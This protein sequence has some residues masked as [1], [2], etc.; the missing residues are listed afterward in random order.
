[1]WSQQSPQR[2]SAGAQCFCFLATKAHF[3]SS[4][5]S[6][7]EGGKGHVLV[8]AVVGVLA[9]PQGVADDRVLIDPRQ[10]GGLAHAAAV[11]EVLEDGQGLGVG[12]ANAE[13]GG[14]LALGEALL[15]GAAGEHPAAVAAVVEADAEV[16]LAAQTVVLT[17]GVLTAEQV[18]LIHA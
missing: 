13:E 3:S 11:L 5:I 6:W 9:G 7:V 1:M 17:V 4:W 8:V 2:V 16:A 18:Q 12:Q 10:A 15:A 14:A